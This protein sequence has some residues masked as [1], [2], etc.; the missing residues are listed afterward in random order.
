MDDMRNGT[1]VLSAIL[2]CALATALIPSGGAA[3]TAEPIVIGAVYSLTGRDAAFGQEGLAGVNVALEEINANGGIGGR[4]MALRVVDDQSNPIL[5][6]EAV[7]SLVKAHHPVAIIGSN[8]SMVTSAAA[9]AAQSV[10]VPLVVPEAT[11]PAITSIGDWVY[12]VCFC[13]PDMSGALASYAY[14]DLGLRR[15]AIL[16][17]ERHDYTASLSRYFRDRFTALGGEIVYQGGY[18]AGRSDFSDDL[19]QVAAPH[20]DAILV[21]GFYPEAGAIVTAARRQNLNVAFLGGDGWESDGLFDVAG[22]AIN[23]KSRIYIASHFSADAHRAKVRG[24]VDEFREQFGRRPNT[25]S[26]LGYDALGVIAGAL[27]DAAEPTPAALK[28]ALAH[29]HHE[30]VTGHIEMNVSRNPT[31]KVIILKAE[32]ARRFAYVEAVM[33]AQSPPA[34]DAIKE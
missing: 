29:A 5:A 19:R 26:A 22:D 12:R 25:S 23:D 18:P 14:N 7:R 33:G 21:S 16:T 11:N 4:P 17:E 10:G 8:T 2:V 27:E 1:R 20:P 31:K 9:V 28:A 24:F 13:D 15:V 3:Q 6:A 30:G 34:E 32:P